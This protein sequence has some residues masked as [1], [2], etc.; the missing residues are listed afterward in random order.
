MKTNNH[1]KRN[2]TIEQAVKILR[3]NGIECDEKEAKIILDFLYFL[4]KLSV[5]QYFNE[6]KD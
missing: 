6:K 3:K 2:I 1:G 5:N 4:A